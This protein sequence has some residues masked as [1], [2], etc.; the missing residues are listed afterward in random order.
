MPVNEVRISQ[1]TD[2]DRVKFETWLFQFETE[3]HAERFKS[4]M[5][6]LPSSLNDGDT[7]VQ[8]DSALQ[9]INAFGDT[10]G[11]GQFSIVDAIFAAR[12]AFQLD[13]GFNGASR[14]DPTLTADIDGNGSLSII[15]AIALARKAFGFDEPRIPNI[16]AINLRIAD[17]Q[18]SQELPVSS[19]PT[20]IVV[21][22]QSGVQAAPFQ[23]NSRLQTLKQADSANDEDHNELRETEHVD[24]LFSDDSLLRELL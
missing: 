4:A 8:A 10:N 7:R 9:H 1:L 21:Q 6:E 17:N 19:N 15:D 23:S 18:A 12:V 14:I 5:R 3:W 2:A 16:P 24:S 11:D 13:T 20:P 22:Q